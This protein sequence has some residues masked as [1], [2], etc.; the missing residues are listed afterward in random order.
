MSDRKRT[1]WIAWGSLVLFLLLIG[2]PLSLGPMVF[3]LRKSERHLSEPAYRRLN[4]CGTAFY[5]PLAAGL[6]LLPDPAPDLYQWYGR[7]WV[8]LANE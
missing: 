1:N 5:Y 3:L 6:Q 8:D 4:A 7:W 2:Y